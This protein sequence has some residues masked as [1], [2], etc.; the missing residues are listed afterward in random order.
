MIIYRSSNLKKVQGFHSYVCLERS[1][2]NEV[3]YGYTR[4]MSGF[5]TNKTGLR[6]WLLKQQKEK[7]H[8]LQK[9]T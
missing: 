9:S 3:L 2:R 4:K 8:F 5:R 6:K 7:K 1:E